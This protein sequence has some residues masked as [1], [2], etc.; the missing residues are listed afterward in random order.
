VTIEVGL[1]R[2]DPA[3]VDEFDPVA[4]DIRAVFARGDIPGLRSFR[5]SSAVEDPGRW[6]V[7]VEWDSIDDHG[8]FVDS[9]EG[10][11][12]RILLRRFMTEEA[13]VFHV[14]PT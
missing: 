14:L 6:V 2:I 3:R 7:L 13:E 9:P 4:A 1:F 10:Q 11:R 8:R 5:I 12:Q